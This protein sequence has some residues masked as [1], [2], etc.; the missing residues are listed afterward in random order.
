MQSFPI[1]NPLRILAR[2]GFLHVD[3]SKYWLLFFNTLQCVESVRLQ[4]S[5]GLHVLAF[6]LNAEIYRANLRIQSERGKIRTRKTHNT[7][8]FYAALYTARCLF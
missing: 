5:S 1:L 2:N 3:E 8:I 4:I 6:G 7:D